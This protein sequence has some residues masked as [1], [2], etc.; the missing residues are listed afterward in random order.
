M[1]KRLKNGDLHT[2]NVTPI[3]KGV[4]EAANDNI[5]AERNAKLLWLAGAIGWVSVG[6]VRGVIFCLMLW[7]RIPLKMLLGCISIMAFVGVLL[8]WGVF[9]DLS[10]VPGFIAIGLS[11]TALTWTYDLVLRWLEP[12]K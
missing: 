3:R 12:S 11:C 2:S 5:R 9:N 6:I 8:S 4:S 7:L 1:S 10:M